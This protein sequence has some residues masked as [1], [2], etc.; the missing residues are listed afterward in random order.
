M[1]NQGYNINIMITRK[2]SAKEARDNFSELLG[3]VYFGKEP[4]IVEKQGTP[5]AVVINPQEYQKFESYKQAAKKRF[6]EIVDEIRKANQDK[7]FDEVYRDVTEIVE[8]VRRER[9]V[10]GK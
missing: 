2:M 1:A 8:D 6:F 10:K 9:H 3:T 4:V 7:S 5:Y